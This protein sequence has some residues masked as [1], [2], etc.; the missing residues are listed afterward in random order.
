MYGL[1][2]L[3]ILVVGYIVSMKLLWLWFRLWLH[4]WLLL[5]S[6]VS[7]T[8]SDDFIMLTTPMLKLYLCLLRGAEERNGKPHDN[9]LAGVLINCGK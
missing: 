7:D 1:T 6:A 9:H 8:C 3:T 2:T 5:G 4:M